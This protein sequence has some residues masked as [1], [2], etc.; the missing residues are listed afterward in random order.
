MTDSS[1]AAA[2]DFRL[3]PVPE[4]ESIIARFEERVNVAQRAN[5]PTKRMVRDALRRCGAARCPVRMKRLSLDVI[6][7]HGDALAD[8]FCQF[9]D[10]ALFLQPYDIF[11]GY[12]PPERTKRINTV[13]VLMQAAEWTDEWGTT[14]GHAFGGVGA[15]PVRCPIEDW[16]QLDDYLARIPDP[17]APGRLDAARQILDQ[18]R[19]SKYCVGMAHL[20]LFERLHC[21]RGM[22]NIFIDLG[23]HEQEVRRLLGA[24]TDYLLEIVRQWGD[25]QAD[26]IF[27]TDDWGSQ[28]SLMISPAMWRSYFK[29]HY[30]IIFDE[31][32]RCGMDIIFHSCGNVTAIVPDLVELGVDVLDPVQPGAMDQAEIARRFGGRIAFSGAID[33]QHL[34]G[35]SRPQEV[36][37]TVR[38]VIET[39]GVPFG[40][41]LL[42]APA[43]VVT[44]EVPIENLRA[45]FEACHGV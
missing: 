18:H 4:M 42:L 21:L 22:A 16:S 29:P 11:I 6:V 28:T 7:R 40:N 8:L 39:L 38:R 31:I 9:P 3:L 30:R 35:S 12:Q 41:A 19:A 24:L 15:T 44:P 10:D 14:W 25:M 13:Q 26:A 17:R 32:H 45:L 1:Y 5:A 20:A 37:D 43:N 23:I 33:D 2:A 27:L 34:L 36:K